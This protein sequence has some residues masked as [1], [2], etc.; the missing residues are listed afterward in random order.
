MLVTRFVQ[1]IAVSDAGGSRCAN[2]ARVTGQWPDEENAHF[3]KV[4]T[5]GYLVMCP[6]SGHKDPT[7]IVPRNNPC[8]TYIA[9]QSASASALKALF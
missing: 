3:V 2:C 7:R 4:P 6:A 9:D 5:A 8:Q 1:A